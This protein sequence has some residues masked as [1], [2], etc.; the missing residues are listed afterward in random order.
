[1]KLAFVK[2][3]QQDVSFLIFLTFFVINEKHDTSHFVFSYSDKVEWLVIDSLCFSIA[4]K[5][6]DFKYLIGE[7]YAWVVICSNIY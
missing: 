5:A 2:L 1:M 4:I 6:F 7:N 3:N